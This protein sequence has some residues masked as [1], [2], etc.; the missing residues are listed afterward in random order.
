MIEGTFGETERYCR[1]ESACSAN[2]LG[3]ASKRDAPCQSW[4]I[5]P[6]VQ[7]MVTVFLS[8]LSLFTSLSIHDDGVLSDSQFGVL[9][10]ELRTIVFEAVV[11]C[12]RH[13]S[14][15]E[16]FVFHLPSIPFS[17]HSNAA[18]TKPSASQYASEQALTLS[19][20]DGR[21]HL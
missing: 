7:E 8:L 6:D 5:E 9:L 4:G 18:Q 2:G 1:G 17:A 3:V 21:I 11:Q 13:S 10:A 16:D 19:S 20:F 14:T 12:T 15:L